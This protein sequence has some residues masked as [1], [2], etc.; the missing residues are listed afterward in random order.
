MIVAASASPKQYPGAMTVFGNPDAHNCYLSARIPI[1]SNSGIDTC[2][3]A[4]RGGGLVGKDLAGTYTNRAILYLRERNVDLAEED[5]KSA[6]RIRPNL[7]EAILNR[8]NVEFFRRNYNAAIADYTEALRLDTNE[9]ESAYFNR[10]MAQER[11]KRTDLAIADFKKA[12]E[13]KPLW[14]LPMKRLAYYRV[15][16]A[17]IQ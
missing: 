15:V 4:L 6:L 3:R 1:I 10:G 7:A 5:I 13:I 12:N 2:S 16:P 17:T 9:P 8:G 14:A 11:L